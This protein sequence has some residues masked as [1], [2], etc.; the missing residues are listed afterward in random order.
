MYRGCQITLSNPVD[1]AI[2]FPNTV[3]PRKTVT[4]GKNTG[5]RVNEG[6]V[7]RNCMAVLPRGQ[8]KWPYYQGSHKAGCHCTY[9][10]DSDLFSR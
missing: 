9:P 1:G 10:L 8:K 7:T 2:G 3:E 6:F 4:N 5:D